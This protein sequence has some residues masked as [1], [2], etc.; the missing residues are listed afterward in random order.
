MAVSAELFLRHASIVRLAADPELGGATGA[1]FH[2]LS[3]PPEH[4]K[5]PPLRAGATFLQY[6]RVRELP[7]WASWRATRYEC[8]APPVFVLREPLVHSSAGILAV[9]DHVL[10]ETLAHTDPAR[11]QYRAVASGIMIPKGRIRRLPGTHVS[12]LA[13]AADNYFH[14]LLEGPARLLAV[15]P[16]LL[17]EAD[18][19]LIPDGATPAQAEALQRLDLP[20]SLAVR[21]VRD[22][23]TLRAE[24]LILPLSIHGD[25]SFHPV[26]RDFFARV[27]ASLPPHRA[28]G[29]RRLWLDRRGNLL[30][31]LVNEDE[32]IA[33]LA[34]FGVEPVRTAEMPLEAQIALFQD[35][36]LIVAPHGAALTN[37]GFCR[38]GTPVVELLMDAYANW[39]FRHLAALCRL[40]YD[41]VLGQ[42]VGDWPPTLAALHLARWQVSV[43][44][45]QA[46]V[47]A[48]LQ[49]QG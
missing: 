6:W 17:A 39:V 41:C 10:D 1:V 42:V 33:A 27:A 3:P 40:Q 20:P 9:T 2:A 44:H 35:A 23:E 37:L 31:P 43:P 26:A 25:A 19:L 48:A 38:P 24:R 30:R 5:L 18:G 49:G 47:A 15:P 13:G 7:A 14:A 45:V 8:F 29:P 34:P 16:A 22:D 21:R 36:E 11:N 32:I 46:A 28:A 12:L 4:V